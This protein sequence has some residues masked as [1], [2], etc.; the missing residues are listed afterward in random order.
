[1]SDALA[2]C[3]EMG[4]RALEAGR[5][6]EA[7][8][9][10]QGARSLSPRDPGIALALANAQRLAGNTITA[11][12]TL[13]A[14]QRLRPFTDPALGMALGAS[15]LDAGAP[16][17]AAACFAR[18]MRLRPED[19]API[20]AL[21]GARRMSGA[22][23]EALALIDAA[24]RL[25]PEHPTFL[26]T[27]AQVHH[28]LGDLPSAA[29]WLDRAEAARPGHAPTQIQR[30][31]TTLLAGASAT[32][33]LHFEARP[34]P[35]P[36]SAARAWS[37]REPLRGS[38][39]LVT[40][41]QGIGDQFQFVR[42]VRR[43]TTLG[44]SRVIVECHPDITS[45]LRAS[46]FDAVNRGSAPPTDWHVPMLSLPHRLQLDAD[47]DGDQVPYLIPPAGGETPRD[48]KPRMA[49]RRLGLVW[50][51]NPAFSGRATRDLDP[52][53]L[54][55]IVGI[56]GIE[57]IS[58]QHGVSGDVTIEGLARPPLA[59][60][61]A[62]TASVLRQLD[63]LVTTDTGI[64]HLAGALGVPAWVL[65]QFVPDWRWG[66]TGDTTPW[67]PSLRLLRQ[68]QPGDWSSVID[69]LGVQLRAARAAR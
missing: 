37:G 42:F 62:S 54:S 55:G 47:V 69:A 19:P 45:L 60:D 35:Q 52:A 1:M 43:L 36:P 27:A 29:R 39:I 50:A 12:E 67:Y 6:D 38:S 5:H 65:L 14:A 58:L 21:A 32:G 56:E 15:L 34:L 23:R 11:R 66:L 17:E 53:L 7:V 20:A 48:A 57:W 40:A 44:A 64:A 51:G 10:F 59:P 31:Y 22:P 41:E 49:G 33:W 16:R 26:L 4:Q 30:A 28:D 8:E 18:V 63:G 2:S 13:I 46:G 3:L 68:T 25:A 61:W 9:A 24:L